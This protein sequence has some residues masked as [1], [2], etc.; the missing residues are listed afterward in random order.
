[1]KCKSDAAFAGDGSGDSLV[2]APPDGC[3]LFL[4]NEWSD[5]RRSACTSTLVGK[6]I[7]HV[8]PAHGRPI[9]SCASPVSP[10][11]G[12]KRSPRLAGNSRRTARE[13]NADKKR[14]NRGVPAS[15]PDAAPLDHGLRQFRRSSLFD[16]RVERRR[17]RLAFLSE[18]RDRQSNGRDAI[19]IPRQEHRPPI[20][21][22]A[23]VACLPR[24]H[25]FSQ[26]FTFSPASRS[27]GHRAEELQPNLP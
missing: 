16:V 19:G 24:T 20:H 15:P 22:A 5:K 10:D 18:D 7:E 8:D 14:Q 13:S 26:Q 12:V 11:V 6:R 2:E 21:T 4:P 25:L 1:M 3:R 23:G 9:A 27:L 17:G